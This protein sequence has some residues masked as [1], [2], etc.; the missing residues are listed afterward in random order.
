ML[1]GAKKCITEMEEETAVNDTWSV[2]GNTLLEQWYCSSVVMITGLDNEA[3]VNKCKPI[4]WLLSQHLQ[5]YRLIKTNWTAKK[6]SKW[7][8]EK[9]GVTRTLLQAVKKRK[10][11]FR[12]HTLPTNNSLEKYIIQG[13]LDGKRAREADQE[14]TGWTTSLPGLTGVGLQDILRATRGQS[15]IEEN[16]P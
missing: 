11:S 12:R 2:T 13:T 1:A 16:H 9:P 8:L 15:R 4:L 5:N 14:W 10:L 3:E 7:V 6:T